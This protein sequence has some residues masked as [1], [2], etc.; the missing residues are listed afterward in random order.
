MRV[1]NFSPNQ[2]LLL[3]LAITNL[4]AFLMFALDKFKAGRPGQRRISEFNLAAIGA[5][6]GWPGGLA[7]MLLFR[8]KTAKQSFQVKYAL[9]LF[10]W[11]GLLFAAY[12]RL[13][14][15]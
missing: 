3:W 13:R 9:A 6:G 5:V 15:G 7:A 12:L 10:V 11:A 4:M 2:L 1:D 14:R 8:H